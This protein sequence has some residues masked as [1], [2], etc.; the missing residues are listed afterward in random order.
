MKGEQRMTNDSSREVVILGFAGSLRKGSFNKAL[1][2]AA[3][4]LCP[5]GAR[6]VPHAIGDLPLYDADIDGDTKPEPVTRLK[7][8]IAA[9]DG[10]LYVSPEYNYGVPGVLKNAIDWASRPGYRSVLAQKPSAII[11]ASESIVGA[12]RGQGQLKQVLLGVLSVVYPRAEYLLGSAAQKLDP[13]G[14]LADETSRKLLVSFL[15]DF[16]AFTRGMRTLRD[17]GVWPRKA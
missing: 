11:G 16:S 6:I 1:L 17:D 12:A 3:V 9:A 5:P 13:S 7:T 14:E 4:E 15:E 2:R 8:A 10:V